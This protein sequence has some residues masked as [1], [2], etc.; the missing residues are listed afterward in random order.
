MNVQI[1]E[2]LGGVDGEAVY[3]DTEGSFI[4]ERLVEIAEALVQ[5]AACAVRA[6]P[7]DD[8]SRL[9][10]SLAASLTRDTILSRVHYIRVHDH[11]EQLAVVHIL[12]DWLQQHPRVKIVITD[13]VAFHFRHDFEDMR[14]RTRLLNGMAQSLARLAADRTVAVRA[15]PPMRCSALG[16]NARPNGAGRSC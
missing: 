11:V 13:S 1:P 2:L 5:H 6:A 9:E 14:L 7:P 8:R 15:G 16:A 3:V 12:D 10:D 4:V